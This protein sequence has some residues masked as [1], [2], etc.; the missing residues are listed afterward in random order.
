MVLVALLVL[1]LVLLLLLLQVLVV[2]VLLLVLLLAPLLSAFV[3]AWLSSGGLDRAHTAAAG[4]ALD[5]CAR[6]APPG[7]RS[8][9]IPAERP[10][11]RPPS[12]AQNGALAEWYPRRSRP[13]M[14]G[15]LCGPCRSLPRHEIEM[16][17]KIVSWLRSR[18]M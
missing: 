16:E 13:T 5:C 3:G 4:K 15:S 6:S 14:R 7:A 2:V 18:G 9:S 10:A 12:E 17:Q 8:F 11:Q 1:P